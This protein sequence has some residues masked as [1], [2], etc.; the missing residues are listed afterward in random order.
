MPNHN[1]QKEAFINFEAD[2]WFKR[3][4]DYISKYK[5]SE[6][7]DCSVIQEYGLNPT[8]ILEVGCSSGYR[9]D[10]LKKQ[11]PNANVF[12]VEPSLEAINYGKNKYK[13][14]TFFHTTADDIPLK[15]GSIDLVIIGFV[16]Y[17]IDRRLLLK[18]MGEIDR[19]LQNKGFLIIVDFF[20]ERALRN[21]YHHIDQFSAYT[22][23][24]EYDSLF[25][26]TDIYHL[27]DRSCYDHK[28]KV[29]NAHQNFQE[30]YAVSLL[31]KDLDATY[32]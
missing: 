13:D 29:K 11:Y 9:L 21:T 8:N 15:D 32:K 10:G 5:F 25:S 24:Q 23:K 17:I 18:V 26:A 22:F 31:K 1:Q 27:L 30:M 14:V 19:V 16:L 20:T 6:D 4:F 7:V 2:L 3:N 28:T 12:G